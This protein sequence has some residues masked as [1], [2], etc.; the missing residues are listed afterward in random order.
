M[1]HHENRTDGATN[2]PQ[3]TDLWKSE[4]GNEGRQPRGNPKYKEILTT[5]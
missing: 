1:R 2:Y 4:Q 5:T 3:R